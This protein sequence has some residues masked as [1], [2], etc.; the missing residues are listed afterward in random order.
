VIRN[1]DHVATEPGEHRQV[2][3]RSQ[4]RAEKPAIADL[5]LDAKQRVEHIDGRF[6]DRSPQLVLASS[7]S[8]NPVAIDGGDA[9]IA[10]LLIYFGGDIFGFHRANTTPEMVID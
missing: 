10:Q 7:L 5:Q 8:A 9:Q 3:G 6:F 1:G 2:S 4:V